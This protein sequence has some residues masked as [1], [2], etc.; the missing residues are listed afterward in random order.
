[1]GKETNQNAQ[2]ER[3]FEERVFARF[4][5][6]DARTRRLENAAKSKAV[7]KFKTLA[8]ILQSVALAGGVVIGGF[9]ALY[10]FRA[11]QASYKAEAEIRQAESQIRQA[12]AQIRQ[13]ELATR[14]QGVVNITVNAGQVSIPNDRGRYIKIDIQVQNA[15]NRNLM[16]EFPEYA[17]TV[18][19]V[20]PNEGGQLLRQWYKFSP[21]P[22]LYPAKVHS[23]D[24]GPNTFVE[25]VARE[26][27]RAGQTIDYPGWF[28]VEESG[29]YLITFVG[30]LKGEDLTVTQQ[31]FGEV[32]P[33]SVGE[34][35][36]IVVK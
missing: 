17:L 30:S 35:T 3:S 26:L 36:F 6:L 4:D 27:V 2:A 20:Q 5:S 25:P 28:R 1:M 22:S 23:H 19:K 16:L 21:I 31:A 24:P 7:G 10:K 33:I 9:W 29:L 12:D 11:L 15:G 32:R 18:A 34:H 14:E 13:L 8:E